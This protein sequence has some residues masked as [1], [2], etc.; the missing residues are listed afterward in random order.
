M[1]YVLIFIL[2]V[3]AGL[4]IGCLIFRAPFGGVLMI[5]EDEDGTYLSAE[6]SQDP[7]IIRTKKC[8]NM[9]IRDLHNG[10][11]EVNQ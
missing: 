11:Y 5:T 10:Y 7:S 2:G 8:V 4:A 1:Y 9:K 3:V 6:L